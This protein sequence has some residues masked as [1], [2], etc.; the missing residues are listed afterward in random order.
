LLAGWSVEIVNPDGTHAGAELPWPSPEPRWVVADT[1]HNTDW[2]QFGIR[3]SV[4]TDSKRTMVME[5]L[6]TWDAAHHLYVL[7]KSATGSRQ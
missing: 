5:V 7:G 6:W 2:T 1:F 3:G 4:R